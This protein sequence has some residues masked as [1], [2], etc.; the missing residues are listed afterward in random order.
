MDRSRSI[1]RRKFLQQ[2]AA[3]AAGAVT[4]PYFVAAGALAG[5]G[6]RGAN[7]RIGV[8]YVGVGRRARQLMKL[9]E[10]GRLVAASDVYL[11]RAEEIAAKHD[12]TA[13]QDYRK[14][15]ESKDVDAVIV[16]T[17]DH[18]HAL[19]S[20]HACQAGK[21]V[22]CEKP[23]TLT[24]SEGR[25]MVEAVRKHQRVFQTGSQQRSMAVNRLGCE[26]IRNGR[27]GKLQAVIG[28][29]YPSPWE[30]ELPSQPAPEGL[31]WD[32][33]CG[34][35]EPRAYHV[36]LFTPRANPG[37]IS[38]RPYSGGEITGW[39][40]HGLDQVQWALGTDHTGPV[41]VWAEGGK[42][43]APVYAE[44]ES[45]SRGNEL[46]SKGRR[47]T[48]R[49]ADGVTLTL[50][51]GPGGGAI[52]IGERG[53]ITIDRNKLT[54]EPKELAEEPI[55]ESDI[56]LYQSNN[57]MQNW[58]DCM[59]SR[60]LPVAGV[61]IGHRSA[62]VCH[63]ANIARWLGRKLRW[64]PDTETFP[65][66]DEANALLDRPQRKPYELPEVV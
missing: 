64:D 21:D 24:V 62:T 45:R 58:F 22:Y 61:E 32:A 20:I 16:A 55:K 48:F 2:G 12:A 41:E 59:K 10:D 65:G 35:T 13:Y 31:D 33:W 60:E 3:A 51:N 44:P 5:P 29:N 42:L 27:L 6:R 4:L 36:D 56:R 26:L 54:A 19:P 1:Q 49:Y 37:W 52:F 53:K 34:Q 15:L 25:R 14:M 7:D 9:P 47:V 50:D 38:F 63:L 17:P 23:M 40:A 30:C 66:D 57:H 8:G 11:K 43:D 39:G 18:W 46:C 28:S